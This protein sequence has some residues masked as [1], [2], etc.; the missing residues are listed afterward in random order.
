MTIPASTPASSTTVS[1]PSSPNTATL[2]SMYNRAAKAFLNRDISLT[3]SLLHAAFSLISAP[4]TSSSLR[5]DPLDGQRRKWDVLRITMETTLYASPRN[6]TD[7]IPQDLRELLIQT[8]HSLVQSMYARSLELFTP[9]MDGQHKRDSAYLPSQVLVTLIYSTLKLDCPEVGRKFI[10]EWLARWGLIEL[11]T[12]EDGGYDKV[13][14]LYCL[15]VLPKVQD[16]AYAREF[17]DYETQLAQEKR[18]TSLRALHEQYLRSLAVPLEPT[19]NGSATPNGHANKR[20]HSPASTSSSLSTTS[21]HTAV[22]STPRDLR[23]GRP[24][25]QRQRNRSSASISS[26]DSTATATPRS[27]QR[28]SSSRRSPSHHSSSH[29]SS[30]SA[31]LPFRSHIQTQPV[32]V[33]PPSAYSLIKAFLQ[34]YFTTSKFTTFF[35]LFIIFPLVSLFFRVRGRRKPVGPGFRATAGIATADL[36]RRRLQAAEG[37]GMVGRV[38]GEVVRAVLD[39]VKMGGSGLV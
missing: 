17:L 19:T 26:T 38:W 9:A 22:P 16:W 25:L 33:R 10:E 13:V 23:K 35:V 28:R 8:P 37:A 27:Q 18:E 29:R 2:R 21:T 30:I 39:T 24:A 1:G 31:V 11:D 5:T 3:N 14:E 32:A 12:N 34:P 6:P 20:S 15:Q 4:P 7:P 36:V